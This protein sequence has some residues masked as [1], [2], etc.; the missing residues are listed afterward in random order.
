MEL[1]INRRALIGLGVAAALTASSLALL[2]TDSGNASSHREAPLI[3]ADPRI[4]N[5]D[6]YAFVSP[7]KAGY[8][9]FI[10]NWQPFQEPQRRTELLPV[11]HRRPL[12]HQVDN[13]G[14]AK[15][16]ITYQWTFQRRATGAAPTRS[17]T[18]TAR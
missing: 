18:T 9:T 11:R 7:D 14:D 10:A 17:S 5:T 6:L 12:Q 1:R 2:R 16:D 4:D 3:A 13:N 8:V 15:P